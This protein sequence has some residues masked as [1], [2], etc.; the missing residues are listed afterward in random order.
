MA[1]KT[2]RASAR[3]C[4]A[5]S[6]GTAASESEQQCKR[7]RFDLEHSA[8]LSE[9]RTIRENSKQFRDF[10]SISSESKRTY[11][12]VERANGGTFLVVHLQGF[13]AIRYIC[14]QFL[15]GI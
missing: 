4:R 11:H 7:H 13:L 2:S 3:G 1:A 8:H 14:D 9:R 12:D 10:G 6:S 15:S 5:A